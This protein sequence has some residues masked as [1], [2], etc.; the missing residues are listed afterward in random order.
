MQD[1]SRFWPGLG[2]TDT[3]YA[4]VVAAYSIFEIALFPIVGVLADRLPYTV[5]TLLFLSMIA[6]GGV[7]Y[8]L[9]VSVW[10][11]FLGRGVIGGA[12]SFGAAAVHMY[13]GEMGTVMDKAREKQRKRPI[14]FSVYIAYSF[15]LNGGYFVAYGKYD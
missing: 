10:M 15:I 1:A 6:I 12:G 3:D 13:M 8:A 14:K 4:L 7:L 11:A 9:A 5:L 2:G